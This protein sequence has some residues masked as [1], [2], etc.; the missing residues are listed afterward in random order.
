MG[1]QKMGTSFSAGAHLAV[2]LEPQPAEMP[3]MPHDGHCSHWERVSSLRYSME[4]E[5]HHDI[6]TAT[7]ADQ[8]QSATT[9]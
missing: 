5:R 7:S 1:C 8:T 6:C 9:L 2:I 3:L 4:H